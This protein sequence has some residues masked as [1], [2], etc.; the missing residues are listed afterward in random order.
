MKPW[1]ETVLAIA[2]VALGGSL[3]LAAAIRGFNPMSA[4]AIIADA[5]VLIGMLVVVVVAFLRARPRP[6]LQLRAVDI[7]YGIGLGLALRLAQGWLAVAAGDDGAFPAYAATGDAGNIWIVA[8]A[9]LSVLI[10]PVLEGLFFQGVLLVT[11]YSVTRR[12][13]SH[14]PA[15]L[16]SLALSTAAFVATHAWTN[17]YS[18][19]AWATPMLVA[20]TCGA[21]VLSTGRVWS[22]VVLHF[23]FNAI[24][25]TLALIG[26]RWG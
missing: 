14:V 5:V 21:L 25:V 9:G 15:I 11:A 8:D 17:G 23:T 13:S 12:M 18:W 16:V 6:L 20:L 1:D 7:M 3:L 19:E 26:T 10:A 24:Y 2:L 4:S 22:S